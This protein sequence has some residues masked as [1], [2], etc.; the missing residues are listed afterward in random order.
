MAPVIS[1]VTPTFNRRVS[2]ERMLG[3]LVLQLLPARDF[4]VIVVDDGSTDGTVDRLR[5]AR[6]PFALKV[7]QQQHRG[8]AAARNLGVA[9]ATADLILFL[10]A[11]VAQHVAA[12]A[13][14]EDSVVIGPMS[15]P[16]GWRRSSW[17][18][19]E[20][21]KL[22]RQYEAMKNG[23]YACTPRQFFTANASLARRR[24]LLSG[25][26]DPAFTRAEDVELGYRL[27]DLGMRFVF[28][29]SAEVLHFASRS[30]ESW[31]RTP[32]QYGRS[33]VVMETR[34]GHESLSA[35]RHEFRSRHPLTRAVAR[36]CVGRPTVASAA[37]ILL[38]GLARGSSGV[39]LERASSLAL[40]AL[41]N[42]QYW[43]G[44][45]DE[46]GGRQHVWPRS[47]PVAA[48]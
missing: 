43:Q 11:L 32:Y 44:V 26:F 6:Y 38:G 5:R 41:F 39:G 31:C 47:A 18:R 21:A 16:V 24:F 22:R 25:G 34:K 7:A 42:L 37:R 40:S 30:F 23:L 3:S 46:L 48:R 28:E 2:L 27:R 20:E 15:P 19:W 33:D 4:E 10:D 36:A 45:C 12:H 1:I 29:P 17:I 35:A 8:P 14:W 13:A 9:R